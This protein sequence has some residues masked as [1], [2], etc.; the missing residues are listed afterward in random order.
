MQQFSL[1]DKKTRLYIYRVVMALLPIL[2]LAGYITESIFPLIAAFMAAILSLSL[3][4]VNTRDYD[5]TEE[6][7]NPPIIIKENVAPK[8]QEG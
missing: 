6:E 4:D 5:K 2:A 3:A 1:Q 8:T 7:E